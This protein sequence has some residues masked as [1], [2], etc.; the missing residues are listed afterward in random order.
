MNKKK[1][2]VAGIV[3]YN[4]EI[5]R[6]KENI[7]AILPQVNEIIFFD[8][9]SKNFYQVK[10]IINKYCVQHSI[11]LSYKKNMGIA[12]ALNEIAKL[13]IKRK[14]KWLLTLDQDTVVKNNLIDWYSDFLNLP[15]VGQLCCGYEDINIP[16]SKMGVDLNYKKYVAIQVG[17]CITSG[18]LINLCSLKKVGGFDEYLFIDKVDDEISFLLQKN[19]YYTYKINFIGMTHEMGNIKKRRVLWKTIYTSNYNFF[20][21][22]YIARN[23]VIV[24]KR[25]KDDLKMSE[26]V[27][28][29]LKEWIVV[30]LFEK[31]KIKKSKAMFKGFFDGVISKEKRKSYF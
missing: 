3:L 16:G 13:A 22:Y 31:E 6:L 24:A 25:F 26:V 29:Q 4:P 2:I 28:S 17:K 10:K 5:K 21:R 27:I 11:I 7:K 20:R 8:N 18:T 23:G 9:G 19:G 12:H 30:I 14:Y 15:N 1:Y